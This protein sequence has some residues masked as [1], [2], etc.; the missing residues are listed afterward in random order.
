MNGHA[1]L[2][3]MTPDEASEFYRVLGRALWALGAFEHYLV[4]YLVI[5]LR[6]SFDTMEAA[7][8]ELDRGFG[9]TLG[10][11]LREFRKY[12]DLTPDFDR[13]LDAFKA[14]RDWLCHR[15]YRENNTDLLNRQ[16]FEALI[17]RLH[18]FKAEAA[19]LLQILDAS[20]DKW[21]AAKDISQEELE[22]GIATTLERW[23]A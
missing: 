14:E 8:K 19:A 5:V 4:Y 15:I 6:S 7:E 9:F 1:E 20:F 17:R 16:R 2:V 22:S 23:K 10:N 3:A 11:L 21:C 18:A 12:R 13:R